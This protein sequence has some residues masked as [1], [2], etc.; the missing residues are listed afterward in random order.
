M[1]SLGSQK[2][3]NGPGNCIYQINQPLISWRYR[4]ADILICSYIYNAMSKRQCPRDNVPPTMSQQPGCSVVHKQ[5]ATVMVSLWR[6]LPFTVAALHQDSSNCF[7][8]FIPLFLLWMEMF[9]FFLCLFV[10]FWIMDRQIQ[11]DS[12]ANC[13]IL[14]LLKGCCIQKS[15]KHV[16][17]NGL[18]S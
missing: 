12:I 14:S 13:Q 16:C 6:V 8:Y 3:R 10:L 4:R 2:S 15:E 18:Y 1:R 5:T 17:H 11:H 9:L 7:I